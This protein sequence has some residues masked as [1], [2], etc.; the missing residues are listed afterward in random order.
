MLVLSVIS[1]YI[2]GSPLSIFSFPLSGGI[3]MTKQ[4]RQALQKVQ[5][6]LSH[7]LCSFG[8]HASKPRA[9][10]FR[11]MVFGILTA[12]TPIV[13]D[14]ARQLKETI[15]L[16]K[17]LKRLDYHLCQKGLHHEVMK[18]HLQTQQTALK[19][20]HYLAVDLSDIQRSWSSRQEGLAQVYDGSTGKLGPGFWLCNAIG[21]SADGQTLVPAFSELYSLKAET[22]SENRKILHTI[23]TVQDVL[24]TSLITVLDRGGDRKRLM[25]PLI[26]EQIPFIIRQMGNRMVSF[27][28]E[29]LLVEELAKSVHLGK[30]FQVK[31][32]GKHRRKEET[33]RAGIVSVQ[34][35][36]DGPLL[37]L[38]VTHRKGKGLCFFLGFLPDI[39]EASEALSTMFEGYGVRWKIE[40]VHR[41]IKTTYH[42]E[43]ISVEKYV[44]LKNLNAIFWTAISFIYV[45]L[46]SIAHILVLSSGVALLHRLKIQEITGFIYYKL[47]KCVAILLASVVPRHHHPYARSPR[48][49]PQLKLTLSY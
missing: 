41:H 33:Y 28:G 47:S 1:S 12:R 9:K 30:T 48:N 7:F 22:T 21:A 26:R 14:I 29:A 19:R 3:P 31:K 42:W 10:F 46:E 18:V 36:K 11:D 16:K 15:F 23:H 27:K 2:R 43:A 20:C 37:W 8:S 35:T 13:T 44:K 6:R 24:D 34:L 4:Q 45:R 49:Q 25:L 39:T 32:M 17:T 40:E 5:G 38:M